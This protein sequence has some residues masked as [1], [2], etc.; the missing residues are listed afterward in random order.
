M[1]KIR[2]A[3]IGECMA[4]LTRESDGLFQMKF[5][6][7]TYNTAVYVSRLGGTFVDVHFI[8]ATGDDWLSSAQISA[9][10]AEGLH[11]DAAILPGATPALYIVNTDD[12]GERTFTYF[13]DASPVRAMLGPTWSHSS[14]EQLDGFDLIYLSAVTLQ[15]LSP[16][17]REELWIRIAAARKTGTLVAF[18]SNYRARGWSSPEAADQAITDA[19]CH[20][21]IALPSYSD[22]LELNNDVTRQEVLDRYVNAGAREVVLKDGSLP[23]TLWAEGNT[24][25][26]PL[27]NSVVPVDTTGAGDSF[28]AGYLISRL[29][30]SSIAESVGR[31]QEI[32]RI[33][34]G[35][36]GGVV[37]ALFT[38]GMSS[39]GKVQY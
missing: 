28:N 23:V 12:S 2:V 15:L 27:L 37:D 17:A 24:T 33:V 14:T 21:D 7:D 22:E 8:T 38:R 32:A 10:E 6:G 1:K 18:D 3:A 9:M 29:R 34:V 16:S 5:A 11:V 39:T 31:A 4:E 20:I 25:E 19:L 26:Y 36:R 30:G 35:A 13:R